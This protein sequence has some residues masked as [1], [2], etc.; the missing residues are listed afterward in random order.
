MIGGGSLA[1][2]LLGIRLDEFDETKTSY[3]IMDPH[4]I[5]PDIQ[6]QITDKKSK[7]IYWVDHNIFKPKNFY[8]FL[9]PQ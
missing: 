9:L 3:L 5:G 2:I 8:N 4:Y 1:Y 6:S 7:G